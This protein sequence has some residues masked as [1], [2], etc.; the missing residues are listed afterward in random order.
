MYV[1]V[2]ASTC[3]HVHTHIYIYTQKE[4]KQE[5]QKNPKSKPRKLLPQSIPFPRTKKE[6]E[7]DKA[8]GPK[9]RKGKDWK[10]P[11]AERRERSRT[12]NV[13]KVLAIP[14]V[15][16]T[17]ASGAISLQDLRRVDDCV[18]CSRTW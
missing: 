2:C 5:V 16:V 8:E 6:A 3:V 12:R 9:Q 10:L 18:M 17:G 13:R 14:T 15:T 7:K 11:T 1:C 4:I